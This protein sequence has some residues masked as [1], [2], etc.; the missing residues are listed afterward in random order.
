MRRRELFPPDRGLQVRMVLAAVLTPLSVVALIAVCALVLP[1]KAVLALLAIGAIGVAMA[2]GDLRRASDARLLGPGEEPELQGIVDRLCVAADLPRPQI[3]LERERQPNSWIVD[4][5][6]RAP[7]LHVTRGLLD[8][9]EPMEV[10]AVVAHELAHV[11]HR[12]ATVMTVVGMPGAALY[13]G[14]TRAGWAMGPLMVGRLLGM[15]I[16]AISR[17]GSSALS[18]HRELTAD[19]GAAALTGRPSALV[20]ALMKVSGALAALPSEDLRRVAARDALHLLPVADDAEKVKVWRTHPT[21]EARVAALERLERKMV[22][23]RP[24]PPAPRG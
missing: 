18:R 5:P 9:L 22:T 8:L 14:A 2:V 11:A 23:A 15:V 21:V 1:L 20:S 7:R 12:D 6:R 24:A 17:V 16:G 10:E 3:V 19:A 4:A 13:E